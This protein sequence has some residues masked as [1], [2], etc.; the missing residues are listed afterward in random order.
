MTAHQVVAR[1]NPIWIAAAASTFLIALAWLLR[2]S[3][4]GS[5]AASGLTVELTGAWLTDLVSWAFAALPSPWPLPVMLSVFSAIAVGVLLAWL[6]RRLRY[7]NWSPVGATCLLAALAANAAI[8]ASVRTDHSAIPLMLACAAIIPGIRRLEAVGDVQAEM[9][10]GLMLPMLFLA[11]PATTPLIP[12]L[13]LFGAS[14]DPIAR[15]DGRAYLAMFLV[16]IM[17]S[18]LVL[19]GLLGMLGTRGAAEIIT[20]AYGSWFTYRPLAGGDLQRLLAT[21]AVAIVPFAILIAAYCLQNDRRRQVWSAIAVPA[22]PLYVIA[23]MAVF[24]WPLPPTAPATVL[25]AAAASWLSVAR[26]PV[27]FRRVAI[28]LIAAGAV[29]SWALPVLE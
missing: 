10:F 29:I 8:V 26:L 21:N 11:G 17:P 28:S 1:S 13:A 7:N 4:D 18:L 20:G 2:F 19:I 15:R 5:S 3:D 25:L 14:A 6:Y 22:L 9:G 27:L 24:S 23:G 16:A 12:A